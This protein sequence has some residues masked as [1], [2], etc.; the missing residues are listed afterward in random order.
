M[1]RPS[2]IFAKQSRVLNRYNDV[3]YLIPTVTG[4]A[5]CE[6]LAF[7]RCIFQ[8]ELLQIFIVM[9][10]KLFE[11]TLRIVQARQGHEEG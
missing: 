11:G 9:I 6:A 8:F 5:S 1:H 2:V 7:Y 3:L 10:E 4:Q